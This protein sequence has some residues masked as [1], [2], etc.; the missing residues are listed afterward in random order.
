LT[1]VDGV[2]DIVTD[3]TTNLCTFKLKNKDLDLKAKLDEFAKTNTHIA[4]WSKVE[5]Q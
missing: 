3:I 2:S 5:K 1:K 4:G